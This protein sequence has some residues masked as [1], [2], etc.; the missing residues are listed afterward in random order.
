MLPFCLMLMFPFVVH[1]VHFRFSFNLTSL[2]TF[3]KLS[4]FFNNF[5]QEFHIHYTIRLCWYPIPF[6]QTLKLTMVIHSVW[7]LFD[8]HWDI[9]FCIQK[10]SA[11]FQS[12]SERVSYS[13][14]IQ[15]ES[16]F[17]FVKPS[18]S[19]LGSTIKLIWAQIS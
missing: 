8:I 2:L 9:H 1:S 15:L 11:C 14:Y 10:P 6:C 3:T 4:F 13:F 17:P 5:Q 12:F 7:L 16:R 19:H 18:R